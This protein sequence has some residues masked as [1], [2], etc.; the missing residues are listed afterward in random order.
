MFLKDYILLD[1]VLLKGMGRVSLE[2]VVARRVRP[3]PRWVA[4]VGV[5]GAQPGSS[6]MA[7]RSLAVDQPCGCRAPMWA[8]LV[9]THARGGS[10]V[11]KWLCPAAAIPMFIRHREA[12]YGGNFLEIK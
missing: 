8:G 6:A 7:W 2:C 5:G 4:A 3:D 10:E 11:E 9:V 12:M 1:T